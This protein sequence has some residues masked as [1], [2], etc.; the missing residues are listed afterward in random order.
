[1][2]EKE[3]GDD[4]MRLGQDR[5]AHAQTYRQTDRHIHNT[6][7]VRAMLYPLLL[8]RLLLPSSCAHDDACVCVCCVCVH[9]P[10]RAAC[11][12]CCRVFDSLTSVV[13]SHDA[14]A[15]AAVHAAVVVAVV[16]CCCCCCCMVV[17]SMCCMHDVALRMHGF[18][19][20]CTC[21]C[22][23]MWRSYI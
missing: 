22:M 1:M 4:M 17:L 16:V 23:Y 11:A 6:W 10:M 14:H 19:C 7:E 21:V 20:T 9:L 12:A 15:S 18:A 3:E 13:V 5:H 8:Q 2:R